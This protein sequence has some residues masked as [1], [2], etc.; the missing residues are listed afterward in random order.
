MEKIRSFQESVDLIRRDPKKHLGKV[1]GLWAMPLMFRGGGI[2]R[3]SYFFMRHVDDVLDGDDTTIKNP[4]EYVEKIRKDLVDGIPD[5]S[6]PIE[7]L[8]FK[9][10]YRLERKRTE[11][12]DD[13][14]RFF[15]EGIEGMLIDFDRVKN[16][17]VV[18]ARSLRQGFIDSFGPHFDIS[19]MA[20][21]SRLRSGDIE[22]FLYAQGFAYSIQDLKIDWERG[23]FNIPTEVLN[24]SGL[25]GEAIFSEVA[26][27]SIVNEW[28][29]DE[30][31]KTRFDLDIFLKNISS[32]EK[33]RSANLLMRGLSKR[34]ISVLDSRMQPI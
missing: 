4:G 28:I 2:I 19:L 6:F 34:V 1:L 10:I 31:S 7:T 17:Q 30:S 21:G 24:Q 26:T 12:S 14:K 8:A 3:D 9:S 27:N 33:E 20:V 5:K 13:P 15:L 18:N 16:R 22:T 29:A 11:E 32:C 23:L 25:S